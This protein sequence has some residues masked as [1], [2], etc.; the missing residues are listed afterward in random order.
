MGFLL[1][2][3]KICLGG[4]L[5]CRGGVSSMFI[6]FFSMFPIPF[7]SGLTIFER[8]GDFMLCGTIKIN[9]PS[10]WSTFKCLIK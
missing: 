2:V 3:L 5:L 4:A 8:D 9:D 1:T 10:F 7:Y 6:S